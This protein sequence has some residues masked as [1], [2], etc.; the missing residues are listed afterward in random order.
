M[1]NSEMFDHFSWP[2]YAG[3]CA[4]YTLILIWNRWGWN[5]SL[6]RSLDRVTLLLALRIHFELLTILL[7]AMWSIAHWYTK[8]PHWLGVS[9]RTRRS[10]T[11]TWLDFLF[12]M[13]CVIMSAIEEWRIGSEARRRRRPHA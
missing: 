9:L 4:V 11:I 7:I 12:I 8:L 3:S 6:F 1:T 2:L 10:S 5:R 13:S